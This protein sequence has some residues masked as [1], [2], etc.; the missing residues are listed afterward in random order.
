MSPAIAHDKDEASTREKMLQAALEAFSELGFDGASTREIANRAGVNQGLVNYYFGSKETLWREAV[1][2]AFAELRAGADGLLDQAPAETDR[3]RA[4][5]LIRGF[6][7]F[8][9]RR[10]EF[11]RLMTD[12]GKRGGKRMQWLV[13]H[14]VRFLFEAVSTFLKNSR[15][16][17]LP[18]SEIDPTVLHYIMVGAVTHLFHQAPEFELLT[19]LDPTEPEWIEAHTDALITLFLGKESS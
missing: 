10:P 14:H 1:A 9:A 5:Q 8:A 4:E 18:L 6:V 7:D 11:S 3:E 12:E 17:G 16:S 13:D 2:I 15:G 19:G